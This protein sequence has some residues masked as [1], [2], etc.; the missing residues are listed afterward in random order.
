M[1]IPRAVKLDSGPQ[2]SFLTTHDLLSSNGSFHSVPASDP[3]GLSTVC[4]TTLS[5]DLVSSSIPET[6]E[7]SRH[8]SDC[9]RFLK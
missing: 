5:I 3:S 4:T 2:I 7:F 1:L 6:T 9:T 8:V